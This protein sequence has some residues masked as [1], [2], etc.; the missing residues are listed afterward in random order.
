[1][2]VLLMILLSPN[3]TLSPMSAEFDDSTACY[4]A[5]DK[6]ESSLALKGDDKKVIY[7]VDCV[8][9]KGGYR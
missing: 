4:K 7:S 1:M 3:G 9:K 5:I 2:Y 6:I 8:Q